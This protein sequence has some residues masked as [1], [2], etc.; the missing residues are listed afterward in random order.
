MMKN[1]KNQGSAPQ[2][3]DSITKKNEELGEGELKKVSGGSLR[4][5]SG[6]FYTEYASDFKISE[7]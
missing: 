3:E 1:P 4:K 6:T 5:A 2:K 7:K